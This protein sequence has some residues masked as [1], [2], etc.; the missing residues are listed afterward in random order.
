M[1][2]T[3]IMQDMR[4]VQQVLRDLP[5]DGNQTI[6]FVMIGNIGSGSSEVKGFELGSFIDSLPEP[7]I[8]S[9]IG[10]AVRIA[11]E[12]NSDECVTYGPPKPGAKWLGISH[13]VYIDY[14]EGR[15][16]KRVD[17]NEMNRIRE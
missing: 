14:L 3:K 4:V 13:Q 1:A 6:N 15:D 11:H 9:L 17:R 12:R 2:D 5:G 7:R 10:E 8:N 16:Q